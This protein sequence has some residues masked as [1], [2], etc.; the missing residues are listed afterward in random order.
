MAEFFGVDP[1]DVIAVVAVIGGL[2][3]AALGII[4]GTVSRVLIAR[5][6]EASRRDLAAYV[7]E[8]SMTPDD[9]EKIMAAVNPHD[10]QGCKRKRR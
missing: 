1:G 2:S 7:A 5:S 9:A 4:F 6:R 10:V 8:G 3:I